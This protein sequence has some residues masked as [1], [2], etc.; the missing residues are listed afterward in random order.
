MPEAL[1]WPHRTLAPR[2]R[3]APRPACIARVSHK[4]KWR[5]GIAVGVLT[6]AASVLR[7]RLNVTETLRRLT[8]PYERYR[9]DATSRMTEAARS[10]RNL[11]AVLA[12]SA[13]ARD[14]PRSAAS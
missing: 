10:R 12:S 6:L 8:A 5:E 4:V 13:C 11:R 1:R 3:R 14:S 7:G 9:L 2:S